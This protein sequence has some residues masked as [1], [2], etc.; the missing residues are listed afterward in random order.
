MAILSLDRNMKLAVMLPS[1]EDNWVMG[2]RQGGKLLLTV[3][4]CTF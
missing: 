1:G 2:A 3:F 4:S